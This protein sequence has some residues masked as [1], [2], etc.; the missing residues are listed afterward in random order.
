M[1]KRIAKKI[2]GILIMLA[3]ASLP[4]ALSAQDSHHQHHGP[5]ATT[6][7]KASTQNPLIEEMTKLDNVFRDVV[8]G[9]SLGDGHKVHE[10]LESMHGT[11]EKTHEGVDKGTV[12]LQKNAHRL[13]EFLKM[14]KAFHADL[15]K[16]AHA[17]HKN[18]RKTMLSL[19]KNLLDGCVS[20]HQ[21]FRK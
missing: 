18:E 5:S 8:S 1:K 15:E 4:I 13:E 3:V 9:V 14:D 10:A 6:N 20:C 2:T 17:A 7:D 16:L 19:T 12:N 21:T 11:M